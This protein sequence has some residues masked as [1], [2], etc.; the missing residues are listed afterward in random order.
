MLRYSSTF[1][2]S[3][4]KLED[5]VKH[6]QQYLRLM[7]ARYAENF[8]YEITMEDS[9]RNEIVPKLIIQPLFENC[10]QHGFS[11]IEPP[12]RIQAL[13]KAEEQGWSVEVKDNGKG[14]SQKERKSLLAKAEEVS[15]AELS[16]MQIGGLGVISCIVRTKI[17]T[18]KR[19]SCEIT[20]LKPK[21]ACLKLSVLN[22]SN[23]INEESK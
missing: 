22:G 16:G 2:N 6:T 14:F 10:F 8:T 3:V 20:D 7:K 9:I 17:V 12:Y 5:E 4:A 15:L 19:V 18:G 21:G 23:G 11:N 1:E 13:I